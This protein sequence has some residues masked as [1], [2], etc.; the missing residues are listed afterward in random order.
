MVVILE[1]ADAYPHFRQ[2][3]PFSTIFA[4]MLIL[5]KERKTGESESKTPR[6]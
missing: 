5:L 2:L 1:M 4:Y 3:L 6:Y